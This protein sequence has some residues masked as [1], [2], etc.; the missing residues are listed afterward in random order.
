MLQQIHV[1]TE[2]VIELACM[3]TAK[4]E[5]VSYMRAVIRA[6]RAYEV[7][8]AG[9]TLRDLINESETH[10]DNFTTELEAVKE[11]APYCR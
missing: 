8:E 4:N 2:E 11:G 9:T 7:Q 5:L 6:F 3:Q 10:Y 1:D